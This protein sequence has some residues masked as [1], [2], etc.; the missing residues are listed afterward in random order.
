M[1]KVEKYHKF[2][3]RCPRRARIQKRGSRGVK[4]MGSAFRASSMPLRSASP[5]VAYYGALALMANQ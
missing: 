2:F 1:T 4:A 5:G 3:C